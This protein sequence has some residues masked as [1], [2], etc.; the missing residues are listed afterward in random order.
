MFLIFVNLGTETR[1]HNSGLESQNLRIC[2]RV[3]S[4]L[5]PAGAHIRHRK[6]HVFEYSTCV[7]DMYSPYMNASVDS[8]RYARSECK[9][10]HMLVYTALPRYSNTSVSTYRRAVPLPAGHACHRIL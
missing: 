7:H 8:P 3:A 6:I 1:T 10:K 4:A 9:Q 5:G 2:R